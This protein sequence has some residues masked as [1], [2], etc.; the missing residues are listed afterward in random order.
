MTKKCGIMY[1]RH[2]QCQNLQCQSD[3]SQS[4]LTLQVMIGR[5]PRA[6]RSEAD[7]SMHCGVET[8]V[9]P[10]WTKRLLAVGFDTAGY[11]RAKPASE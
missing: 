9:K 8:A 5:S 10:E 4:D 2:E 6:S 1:G 7:T 11:D 3:C